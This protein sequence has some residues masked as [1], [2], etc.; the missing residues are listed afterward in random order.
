[1]NIES[2]VVWSCTAIPHSQSQDVA[3]LRS[4]AA[5]IQ[6]ARTQAARETF[7]LLVC[8]PPENKEPLAPRR[9]WAWALWHSSLPKVS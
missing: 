4:Q 9:N 1:M 7:K 8:K 5:R 3:Q 6:I 2:P